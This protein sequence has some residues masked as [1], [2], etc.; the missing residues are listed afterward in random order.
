MISQALRLGLPVLASRVGGLPEMVDAGISGDLVPPGDASAWTE[1]L[2]NLL[3]NPGVI[4]RWRKGAQDLQDTGSPEVL[5]PRMME[6]FQRTAEE[7][8]L[9]HAVKTPA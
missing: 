1:M 9:R 6:L 7:A 5:G 3:R 4:A 8:M 2:E